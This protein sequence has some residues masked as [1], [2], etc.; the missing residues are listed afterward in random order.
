MSATC[1][2][3][4]ICTGSLTGGIAA[5][6]ASAV[7]GAVG[8]DVVSAAAW[9]LGQA[10][11]SIDPAVESPTFLAEI[12]VMEH[13]GL[14]VVLPVLFVATIGPV[15]RQDGRRLFRVWAIGLP[16]AVFAGMATAQ[17]TEWALEVTDYLTS[18]F[19]YGNGHSLVSAV[20]HLISAPAVAGMPV[21][22]QMALGALVAAGALMVWL[23][24]MVRS[25]G[26]Y[27]A[28]FFM[29]LVLVAFI[30]PATAGMA[31]R[32]VEILVALIM[33]KFVIV[34]SLTLGLIS[35][36]GS[37]ANSIVSGCGIVL[38][39]AFS[40]FALF[41]LTTVVEA[42]A[43]A[44]LEGYSRRPLAA[45][46]SLA[47]G[48]TH[49]VVQAVMRAASPAPGPGGGAGGDGGP[50]AAAAGPAGPAGGLGHLIPEAAA[51]YRSPSATDAD[52]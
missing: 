14:L 2:I 37:G 35:M 15:L 43:V 24:L 11:G 25:A 47:A 33:S 48:P 40:P 17:M 45:A 46:T 22:V 26:V 32:A 28:T 27:V 44:H 9:L 13:L 39:A 10:A 49:P 8:S 38:L 36:E 50:A 1:G 42:S 34:A 7:I 16:V 23:E 5:D 29:P 20:G 3:L 6:A 31:K 41:R 4:P 52:G 30:W 51:T 12:A 18:V 19:T 21:F